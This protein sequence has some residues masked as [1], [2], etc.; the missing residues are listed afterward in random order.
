MSQKI[1]FTRF[2]DWDY[3]DFASDIPLYLELARQYG[4]PFLEIACGTGRVML[5]LARAGFEIAGLDISEPMLRRARAKWE[6]EPKEVRERISFI[7][8]DMRNFQLGRTFSA[9]L[10]PNASLFNLLNF[11]SMR[12]GSV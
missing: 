6:A 2:Y 7:H 9:V 3:K 5:P 4:S 8:D 1:D 12:K 10:V 11:S